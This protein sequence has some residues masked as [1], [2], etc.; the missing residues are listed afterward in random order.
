[1]PTVRD[2]L[3]ALE[4]VAPERF[5]LEFDKIGLQ[6]GDVNQQVTNA[7]V[8]L[9]RSLGAV[10]FAEEMQSELLLSHHPLIF[11]PI[12]S[13]DTRSHVGRTIAQLVRQ[14]TSFIAAHTNWDAAQGG[15]NDT[16]A[17]LFHLSNVSAFGMSS[18]VLQLKL[19]FTCP[20]DAADSIIDAVSAAGAGVIGAYTRCAFSSVGT[21]TFIGDATTHP[22]VGAPERVETAPELRVE[23][24]LREDQ[25]KAVL[26]AIRAAHPYEEP[27]I[28][29]YALQSSK[30]LPLGRIGALPEALALRDLTAQ[31]DA[32]LGVRSWTW[33]DPGRKIKNLALMGGAADSAWMDAQRA[34]ADALLTG[35]VKQHVGLE[36]AESGMTIIAAGHYQTEHPG[37]A[38]LRDRMAVALPKI[39]WHLFT[40]PPG[41]FG[42]PF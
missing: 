30:E 32:V 13:V 34:G 17:D 38:A 21:G 4:K 23:M 26:R 36:A 8:A 10:K 28:D 31:V 37:A 25:A 29:L 7:V 35:E 40:P 41:H 16:L 18:D 5:A 2:V 33:G 24:A 11:D 6:V 12:S 39:R 3:D 1:M 27:A 20:S 22:S 19:V 15:V 42:R 9:D 14:N